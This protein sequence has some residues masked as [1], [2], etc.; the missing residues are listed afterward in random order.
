M[1]HIMTAN[2]KVKYFLLPFPLQSKRGNQRKPQPESGNSDD[3]D[4]PML[5][6]LKFRKA[7]VERMKAIATAE[8]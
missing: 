5:G 7:K 4:D 8:G 1:T 2:C 3:D 6:F